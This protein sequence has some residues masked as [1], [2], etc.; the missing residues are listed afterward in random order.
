MIQS[1]FAAVPTDHVPHDIV[2][3]ALSP[4]DPVFTYGPEY[5]SSSNLGCRCP[6]IQGFF[7]PLRYRDHTNVTAFTHQIDYAPVALPNLD[8]LNC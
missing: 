5:S 7:D 4:H 6:A 1:D 3:D 8:F 2:G